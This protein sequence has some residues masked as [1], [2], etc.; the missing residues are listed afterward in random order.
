VSQENVRP[1][2]AY[3]SFVPADQAFSRMFNDKSSSGR[4]VPSPLLTADLLPHVLV[5][6]QFE[7]DGQL[8]SP[9]VPTKQN[10]A[11][12]VPRHISQQAVEKAL[13][14]LGQVRSLTDRRRLAAL[15][16]ERPP[17]PVQVVVSPLAPQANTAV[18]STPT[19]ANALVPSSAAQTPAIGVQPGASQPAQ[20]Q[21]AVQQSEQAFVNPSP[22][23]QSPQQRKAVK[24][25][26]VE[27][28]R[29]NGEDAVDRQVRQELVFQGINNTFAGQSQLAQ[30]AF[31]FDAN[32]AN[33]VMLPSTDISGVPMTPLWIE[34]RL[35]LA[36]RVVAGGQEYVQ[37]CLLDWPTIKATLHDVIADLLPEASFEPV[38]G[39]NRDEARMLV[40]L[41]VRLVPDV[42]NRGL[43]GGPF[44]EIADLF[45]DES[46]LNRA[47]V[48]PILVSL[49]VAWACMV[50]AAVAVAGLLAGVLRLSQ[51]RASFVTAVTHELRTPLTTFQMYAEMLA[52]GMVRDA[53]QQ[54]QYLATL[55]AE[56]VRLT[57]L[58]EN[59]LSYARLERG[60]T[61]GRRETLSLGELIERVEGRLAGRTEQAGLELS[62]EG[63]EEARGA[64]ISVNVSAVEQVLFNLVDNACKYA[65]DGP[66]RRLEISLAAVG[67]M[68]EV[69]VR[70]HGPGFSPGV[71]RRLFRPFSKSAREAAHSAPGVGLGLALS[72]RLA[73]DMGGDLRLEGTSRAGTC[74]V[75]GLPITA[76]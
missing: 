74:F 67:G 31:N 33:G 56:A 5:Y 6:F 58:V 44:S 60:R 36:R 25:R 16:P 40:A 37:G 11:L 27:M 68:A 12:A 26:R 30:S 55:R 29:D 43:L 20:Q 3:R 1:W 45:P 19:A 23:T 52:E 13:A 57:H 38:A 34:G 47:L 69:R 48:S 21:A 71:Q 10:L 14:Q 51:R 49:A 15:L 39:S 76:P 35:L 65:A 63:D 73:R 7:P 41:P 62:L 42:S 46:T 64:M 59:V 66:V 54:R 18:A 53:D 32:F 22:L 4:L 75:L 61:D 28:Q 24:D 8:T 50:L 72:R 70:D 2:F 9:Q 17:S